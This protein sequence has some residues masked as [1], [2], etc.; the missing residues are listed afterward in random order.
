MIKIFGIVQLKTP[1]GP[2]WEPSSTAPC[3]VHECP[4]IDR[5]A[6]VSNYS[7]ESKPFPPS[8]IIKE[9]RKILNEE[10]LSSAFEM[11]AGYLLWVEKII[12]ESR[13]KCVLIF[14]P[15][16]PAQ[17]RVIYTVAGP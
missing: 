16:G 7:K 10:Y 12:V 4:N 6:E 5:M 1:T 11:H 2:V 14:V 3:A 9:G 15:L 17:R 13:G 8:F